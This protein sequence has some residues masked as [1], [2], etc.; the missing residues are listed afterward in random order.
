METTT[1]GER[2]QTI[3]EQCAGGRFLDALRTGEEAFGPPERWTTET[4]GP[5]ASRI[6]A[7]LGAP[8]RSDAID[9]S[10]YRR[11]PGEAWAFARYVGVV[12]ERR[13]P[14]E[15]LRRIEGF[16]VE[17]GASA[18]AVAALAPGSTVKPSIRRSA[19]SGPRRSSTTPTYRA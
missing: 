16:T 4:G 11:H 10:L 1:A 2:W 17:P 9:L 18:G 6:T 14:L 12:L 19:S 5:L 8:R 15:A 3:A 7:H 13:G